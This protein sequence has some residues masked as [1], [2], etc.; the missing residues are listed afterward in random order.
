VGANAVA[1]LAAVMRR[2]EGHPTVQPDGC[3]CL[4]ELVLGGS[5][6]RIPQGASLGL[7][8]SDVLKA[9]DGLGGADVV[10]GSDG[11]GGSDGRIPQE[12]SSGR[13]PQGVSLGLGG[14]DGL[15]AIAKDKDAVESLVGALRR[16]KTRVS[17]I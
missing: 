14:A 12:A 3:L 15:A 7:G 10:G 4:A 13:I 8:S 1:M 16:C 2:H 6:V 17:Y 11:L 9:S 5:D